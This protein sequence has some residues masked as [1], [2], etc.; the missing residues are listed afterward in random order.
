MTTAPNASV[1]YPTESDP[2]YVIDGQRL[3]RVTNCL[4]CFP[5]PHLFYWYAKATA[6]RANDLFS[7]LEESI[8]DRQ[9]FEE[10]FNV[11]RLMKAPTEYR[12]FKGNLGTITHRVGYDHALGTRVATSDWRDYLA[13]LIADEQRRDPEFSAE[14]DDVLPYA[15]ARLRFAEEHKAEYEAVGLETIVASF[16]HLFAGRADAFGARFKASD[17]PDN[18]TGREIRDLINKVGDGKTAIGLLDDKCSNHQGGEWRYQLAAYSYA[19]CLILSTTGDR[20]ELPERQFSANLWVRPDGSED[21][22]RLIPQPCGEHEFEAF[23]AARDLTELINNPSAK[24]RL[25]R[26]KTKESRFDVRPAPF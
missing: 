26:A 5:R 8:I 25:S 2:Y 11:A 20:F 10:L 18:E 23:L 3:V 22:T 4:H 6:E 7:K 13:A 1:V 17:Q 14:I 12:D 21:R 16:E 15:N 24:P 19:D 9:T